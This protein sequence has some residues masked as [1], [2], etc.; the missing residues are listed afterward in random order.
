MPLTINY[1]L[2]LRW[3]ATKLRVNLYESVEEKLHAEKLLPFQ[4][5]S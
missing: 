5:P 3:A 1:V 4:L 2:T